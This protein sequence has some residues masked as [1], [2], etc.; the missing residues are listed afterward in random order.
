[1]E[2]V[3]IKGNT[4]YIPSS[5]NIGV[6]KYKNK[7]CMIIDT[8]ISNTSG[9]KIDE[10]INQNALHVKYIANT[11]CH[12]DHA[13]GNGY[14]LNTYPGCEVYGSERT[15]L[16]LE[17]PELLPSMFFAAPVKIS[18]LSSLVT[19]SK[20]QNVMEEGINKINDEK[21]NVL[22]TN[23]H[24]PGQIALIT[25]EK[26]CFTGDAVFSREI[27]EK[28]KVP[29]ITDIDAFLKSID[30]LC[31]ADADYYVLSHADKVYEKEEF[32][33]VAKYNK[34]MINSTIKDMLD[35][36]SQPQTREGLC[37]SIF[38]LNDIKMTLSEY[39]LIN[40]TVGACINHLYTNGEIDYSMEDGKLYYYAK[41]K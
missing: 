35:M 14:F 41:E 21:I 28:Y 23:G 17:N 40:T 37:E 8:G 32:L 16:Y 11:H 26:V 27:L 19:P 36:M 6:Y 38:V 22:D 3:K 5:T 12:C 2:L 4:Y 9:R 30:K 1:M 20:V 39:H 15:K 33:E 24:C 7:N 25:P 18:S 31:E 10:L 29:N 13:G 34:D